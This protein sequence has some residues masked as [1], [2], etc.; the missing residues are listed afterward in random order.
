[1]KVVEEEKLVYIRNELSPG[2]ELAMK[3]ALSPKQMKVLLWFLKKPYNTQELA[4][5]LDIKP[6]TLH[7][8]VMKLKLR[9]LLRLKGRDEKGNNT[10]EFNEEVLD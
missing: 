10:Y 9:R 4:K 6:G 8:L 7:H 5:E 3:Y 1:M 2:I